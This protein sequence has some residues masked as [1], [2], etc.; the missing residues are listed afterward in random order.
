MKFPDDQKQIVVTNGVNSIQGRISYTKNIDLSEKGYIKLS[1]PMCKI[2]S[3][4]AAEG[5]DVDFQVPIDIFAWDNGV[6]KVITDDQAFNFTLSGISL[7]EDTGF[8]DWSDTSRVIEWVGGL[9]H[10]NGASDVQS[11]TGTTGTTTYAQVINKA[12]DFIELFTNKNTLVGAIANVL[13]QYNTSYANTTNLTVPANFVI[14]GNAYSNNF[15]GVITRTTK[16]QGNAYFFT[17]DGATTSANSG[18]PINDPYI[19]AIRAYKSSW[20]L[21]T[22]SGQL[23]Y[24]NGGGFQEIGYLPTF[25][26]EE[27]LIS[28]EPGTEIQFGNLIDVD[29]DIIYVNCASAPEFSSNMKPYRPGFS[30]G[31]YCYDQQVGFYHRSALS[32]SRYIKENVSVSSDVITSSA[33]HFL[34]TGDEVWLEA[35]DLGLT[36]SRVYFAIVQTSTTF[37]L[38][39]TYA[40]ALANIPVSITNGTLNG[41]SWVKRTDFGIETVPLRNLGFVKKVKNYD[42]FNDSGVTPTF[43]GGYVK[44]NNVASD[45]VSVLNAAVPVMSNRGYFIT[46]KFQTSNL[47]D[48]W[49]SVAVKYQKLS[50]QSSIIVKAKTKDQEAIVVGDASLFAAGTYTGSLVTWD[51]NGT[52]FETSFDISEAEVGDEVHVFDGAG[53]GQSA[54]ITAITL[55]GSIYHVD[56]DEEL[57]GITSNAKSCVS[58]DKWKKIGVIES[59][60]NNQKEFALGDFSPTLE[61]KVEL[62]GVGVRVN[63]IVIMSSSH[64][65]AE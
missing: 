10:I 60:E 5:G 25:K 35:D 53:A 37:R 42:G 61:V 26:F 59:D 8:T 13:W 31:M 30:G 58:I 27:N 24:F 51:A 3:S 23:L 11:Y 62:R 34:K 52:H 7:S 64:Q 33:T 6:Y 15:M 40:D 54:H 57:R 17:W 28:L 49:Q 56:I 55:V 2:F 50:P 46:S 20:I 21:V 1:A 45:R 14:T 41:L 19:L 38:A 22:S 63:E 47:E 39:D 9:W 29:G 36:G 32:Y 43:L 18:F 48:V 16:G 65:R 4:E 12:L 44:P